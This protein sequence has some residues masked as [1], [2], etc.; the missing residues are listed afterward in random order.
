MTK[1]T[2]LGRSLFLLVALLTT[3]LTFNSCRKDLLVQSPNNLKN[4]LSIAEAKSYFN[5]HFP[6]SKKGNTG[7]SSLSGKPTLQ[8]LFANKQPIWDKAYQKMISTGGAVKIPLDFGNV[9]QIVDAKKKAIVP[10]A[11]LNYLL[12]YRDTMGAIHTEWIAL[13]PAKSWLYGSRQ[14]FKGIIQVMDLKVNG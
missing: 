10:F 11:S 6:D 1:T 4:A 2:L 7:L 12:M 8:T 5:S 3:A 9:M 14:V 13:Q